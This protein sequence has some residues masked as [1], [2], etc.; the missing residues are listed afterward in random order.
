MYSKFLLAL[1][2]NWVYEDFASLYTKRRPLSCIFFH[3]SGTSDRTMM[4]NQRAVVK[5]RKDEAIED[6]EFSVYVKYFG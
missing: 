2:S 3:F 1:V 5:M 6:D 4:P